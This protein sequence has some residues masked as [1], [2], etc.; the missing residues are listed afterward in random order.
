MIYKIIIN[1]R[2]AC[3]K[4][5]EL[6]R[7]KIKRMVCKCANIPPYDTLH[8]LVDIGR[9]ESF[10]TSLWLSEDTEKKYK[11]LCVKEDGHLL[12]L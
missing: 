7:I 9:I 11:V 10:K 4:E 12:L 5:G 6:H 8:H 3:F 2:Q 1:W